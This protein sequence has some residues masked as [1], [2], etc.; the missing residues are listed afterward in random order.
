MQEKE[1]LHVAIIQYTIHWEDAAANR[2]YLDTACFNNPQFTSCDLIVLPEMFTTGFSKSAAELAE[3]TDGPT[4]T[5]M[6]NWAKKLQL[7]VI[8]SLI[9]EDNGKHFNRLIVVDQ[10]GLRASYDKKHLFSYGGE[11]KQFTSG[12]ERLTFDLHGWSICPLICYDL[13]FPVWSRNTDHYDLLIYIA[14]WPATRVHHWRQLL[15]AR[16]IENQSYTVGVN[17]IGIDGYGLEYSGS[18][19]AVSYDGTTH[20]DLADK[21]EVAILTFSKSAQQDYR[22]KLPFLQDQD[23][24][25]I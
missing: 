17:R 5:W 18:S 15:I 14:N 23:S 24:F 22:K 6:I 12:N 20:A 9:I 8:G 3:P 1:L 2:A 11:G 13:R 19:L 7:T 10:N 25:V 16:A 21:A 4:I